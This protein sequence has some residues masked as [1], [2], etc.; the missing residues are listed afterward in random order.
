MRAL[1]AQ[2][3]TVNLDPTW[4]AVSLVISTVGLALF[5]YGKKQTRMP[6]M[7]AGVILLVSPYFFS[8]ISHMVGFAFGV[9]GSVYLW[10]RYDAG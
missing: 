3:F 8:D 6:Q 2:G 9:I 7:V 5:R 4:L 10:A 1:G